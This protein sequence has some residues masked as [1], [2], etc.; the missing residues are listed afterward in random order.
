MQRRIVRK[1][2][3][4]G[5]IAIGLL[6]I[7]WGLYTAIRQYIPHNT[8]WYVTQTLFLTVICAACRSLPVFLS[9]NK[10]MDLS[11]ISILMTYLT[12]G[13]AQ[14]IVVFALSSLFTFSFNEQGDK[15]VVTI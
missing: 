15:R 6:L 9:N 8:Q 3:T 12:M 14:A 13:T 11:V 5:V 4:W 7:V 10:A 2:Y 1:T